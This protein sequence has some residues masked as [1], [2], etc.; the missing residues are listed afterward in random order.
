M[1][2]DA[3]YTS[4]I[5]IKDLGFEGNTALSEYSVPQDIIDHALSRSPF[6]AG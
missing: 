3:Y 4:P 5:G 2:V 1:T 6:R